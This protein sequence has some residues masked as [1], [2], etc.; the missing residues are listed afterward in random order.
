MTGSLRGTENESES[1]E[2]PAHK[3]WSLRAK[4]SFTFPFRLPRIVSALV[5]L[6]VF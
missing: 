4:I 2:A 6:E 3:V 1:L 5:D